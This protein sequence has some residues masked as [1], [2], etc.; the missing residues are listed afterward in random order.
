M[1]SRERFDAK[2]E[3]YGECL[4]WTGAKNQN[5]YGRFYDGQ[6]I[7]VAHH[8]AFLRFSGLDAIPEGYVVIHLCDVPGCVNP[9]H[10]ALSTPKGNQFD[11]YRKQRQYT[12]L[13]ARDV[14]IMRKLY[15]TG[16][17]THEQISEI[18]KV[19]KST[20]TYALNGH[21]WKRTDSLKESVA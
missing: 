11:K 6:K 14:R 1:T 21:T 9:D 4:L 3:P 2:T 20:V 19:H 16:K 5:G 18:F 13:T 10:L 15:A 12:R 17:F 7:A 8:F